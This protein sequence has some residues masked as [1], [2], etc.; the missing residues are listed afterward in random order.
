MLSTVPFS[1]ED[2]RQI[3]SRGRTLEE[4][5]AEIETFM[6]GIP[7]VTLD[8]P[9]TVGDGIVR[10]SGEKA[11]RLVKNFDGV[12]ASGHVMKFT[13]ASGA[14]SRMFKLLQ[15]FDGG[16]GEENLSGEFIEFGKGLKNLAFYDD[17][18][19]VI[20]EAGIDLDIFVSKEDYGPVVEY[21]LTDKGL[22]YSFLPKALI[23][24]H[25]YDAYARTP[26]EEHLAEAAAYTKDGNGLCRIHFTL[27]PEHEALVQKHMSEV[28]KKREKEG[29]RFEVTFSAQS[30]A[31]DTLAVDMEDSPF[32]SH[33][34]QLLFRPGGHGALLKNL[35]ELEG[36]IVFIKN[37]DNVVPDRLRGETV[38]CKKMLGG[39][40]ADLQ[41]EIF[42]ILKTLDREVFDESFVS[43]ALQFAEE[44][45]FVDLPS[46]VEG[47]TLEEKI[48]LVREKLNRPIRVCG[49][50]KNEG[51]PGGG[52]FWVKGRDGTVSLQIV[53]KSQVDPDSETQRAILESAT[54]F[55]PVDLVCGLRDYRGEPFNLTEFTDPETGFISTK[56]FEGRQLKA[57]ELPGLWNGAMADWNT[58]F[59]EV[60]IITFNP[61]KT[62]LDLL[63]PEHQP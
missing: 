24:F 7:F 38:R 49:M 42:S 18:K 51:E 60:P 46:S 43:G 19:S 9:C 33:D 53:E 3:E 1:E 58:V 6:R 27:S 22:N 45:L 25:R 2:L 44:K 36:D 4:L 63:R 21:L 15:V 13:P 47:A 54:H 62:V 11:D 39:Y 40:L 57:L 20:A 31:T 30:P 26:I 32:R 14:A 12:A 28:L 23:K 8:R 16:S 5:V 10:F 41:E 55:N 59:V 35:Q 52:P 50:V 37:I 29:L 56:S 48:G 61:V 34:G 17:L